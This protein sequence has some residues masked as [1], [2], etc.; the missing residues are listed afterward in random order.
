M[1]GVVSHM[2]TL[3]AATGATMQLMAARTSNIRGGRPSSHEDRVS[4]AAESPSCGAELVAVRVDNGTSASVPSRPASLVTFRSASDSSSFR[5]FESLHLP[6]ASVRPVRSALL[7]TNSITKV[8][9]VDFEEDVFGEKGSSDEYS[10]ESDT[11]FDVS[12]RG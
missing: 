11:L 12:P 5:S 8:D 4:T 9:E 1:L 2:G 6:T 7:V 10:D 3:A